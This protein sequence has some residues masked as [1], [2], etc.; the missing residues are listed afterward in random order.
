MVPSPSMTK[1]ALGG[2]IIPAMEAVALGERTVGSFNVGVE[3]QMPLLV[4]AAMH[5]AR[6]TE[7]QISWAPRRRD[8]GDLAL[9]A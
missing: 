8:L 1:R 2:A 3:V 9:E 4:N 5:N 7:M 6:S